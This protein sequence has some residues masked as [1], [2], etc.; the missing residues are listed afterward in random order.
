M[1]KW[2]DFK[3]PIDAKNMFKSIKPVTK[4]SQLAERATL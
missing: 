1:N 3:P 4:I 2:D